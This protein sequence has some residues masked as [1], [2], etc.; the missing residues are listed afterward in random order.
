M[1]TSR[2]LEIRDHLDNVDD[3]SWLEITKEHFE[4]YFELLEDFCSGTAFP[5]CPIQ[6]LCN[7]IDKRQ[8]IGA[9]ILKSIDRD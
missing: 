1:W 2:R 9:A 3:G 6:K 4:E 5:K 7:R 8:P